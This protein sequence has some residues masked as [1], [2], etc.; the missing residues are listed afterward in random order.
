MNLKFNLIINLHF[1]EVVN[2]YV[3]ERVIDHFLSNLNFY[4]I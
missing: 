3:M 4:N 1:I 2:R